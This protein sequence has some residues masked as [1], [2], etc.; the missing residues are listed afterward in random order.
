[1]FD[2]VSVCACEA[3]TYKISLDVLTHNQFLDKNIS[4][5]NSITLLDGLSSVGVVDEKKNL[6]L[7]SWFTKKEGVARRDEDVDRVSLPLQMSEIKRGDFTVH[8]DH[9]VGK[10][11]GLVIK[12]GGV[13][14]QEFLAIKY[15][16]GGVLSIDVGR[17][18][19]VGYF[20]P[21]G[22][23]DIKL[24]SLAKRGVWNRKKSSAKRRAEDAVQHLLNL[25]IKRNDIFRLPFLCDALLEKQFLS[26]FSYVDTPDQLRAWEEISSDLSSDSPHNSLSIGESEERSDEISSQARS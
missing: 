1:V 9:G 21:S 18:D 24:D 14:V 11:L 16:D 10:C 8:R 23:E 5:F 2:G 15:S 6:F 12:D 4:L 3:L 20:A 13:D 17:L 22:A 19:L 7:P 26:G 25:Y